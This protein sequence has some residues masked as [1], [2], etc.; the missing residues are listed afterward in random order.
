MNRP[1]EV[2][3]VELKVDVPDLDRRDVVKL[4]LAYRLDLQTARDQVDDARRGVVVGENGLLPDLNL[5]A[6]TNAGNEP[7]NPAVKLN[8]RTNTYS[9]GITLG[10]PV[11]RVAERNAYRRSLIVLEQAMRHYTDAE[12][13][14]LAD[15]RDASRRIRAAE[16]NLQIQRRAIE[17]A[18]RRVDLAN[19]LLVQGTG[20]NRD[21]V[22]AETSLLSAQDSFEQARA[23]LQIQ[24][25]QFLRRTGTLRLDPN[26][27]ALGLAMDRAE[28][29]D[30]GGAARVGAA[31]EPWKGVET[32]AAV[33]FLRP[34]SPA[35]R[36]DA[37]APNI[38][39]PALYCI[40]RN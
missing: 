14:V 29:K 15:V 1:L 37:L 16:I 32:R 3:P 8:E 17:L 27:G 24:V 22:D 6:N 39:T 10:L 34:F 20:S 23:A 25:L 7:G 26:A 4:A 40:E 30:I 5:T 35:P 12:Q 33:R 9:A 11:D 36:P 28:A 31:P 19:E 38:S 13:Q 2:V 18:N 21:V